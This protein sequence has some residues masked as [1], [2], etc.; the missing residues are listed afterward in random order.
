LKGRGALG[1]IRRNRSSRADE[2]TLPASR[3]VWQGG[4]TKEIVRRVGYSAALPKSGRCRDS[5]HLY[6]DDPQGGEVFFRAAARVG[7]SFNAM[8]RLA[9]SLV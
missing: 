8:R 2:A 6:F 4:A 1:I 5:N 7:V 9:E 3:G